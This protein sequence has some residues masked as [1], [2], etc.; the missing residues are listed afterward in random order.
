MHTGLK[1]RPKGKQCYGTRKAADKRTGYTV[2]KYLGY[3][4]RQQMK[5][6]L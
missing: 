3:D 4:E 1:K 5:L 2:K 6:L